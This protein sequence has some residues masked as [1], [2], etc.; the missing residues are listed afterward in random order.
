MLR[1]TRRCGRGGLIVAATCL[2]SGV[3]ASS[4]QADVGIRFTEF[5]L[6][7]PGADNGFEAI[8]INGPANQSLAGVSMVILEGDAGGAGVVDVVIDLS[9]F[10]IGANGLLLLR[11]AATQLQ[12]PPAAGTTVVVQDFFPDLENGSATYL[13]VQGTPPAQFFDIDTN[14]DGVVD[15]WPSGIVIFDAVGWADASNDFTYAA[16][17]GGQA[18]LVSA[19]PNAVFRFYACNA[20][21]AT[22]WA[23]GVIDGANPGPY[24]FSTANGATFGFGEGVVP[25][26][27]LGQGLQFGVSNRE[28]DR[29]ADGT[30]DA[31]DNCLATANPDQADV[32][33]DGV[34]DACDNCVATANADQ[35][36]GDADG[37]GD[38]C[39]NCVATANADQL[40]TDGD[41]LGDAC[42]NCPAVANL[43][44]LDG[45]GDGV[46]DVCDN[47]PLAANPD[48]A[49]T[50]S[51]G[52]ADA[53]DDCPLAF[54]P[55]Q[56][57]LDGD[58]TGEACDTCPGL[59]NP[60]QEDGDGDGLG[61]A[62]DPFGCFADFDGDGLINTVDLSFLLGGWGTPLYDLDGDEEVGSSDIALILGAWGSCP[63]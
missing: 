5:L 41:G 18:Y 59:A 50:D 40:D 8:E 25:T 45:D 60:G 31:C 42:D 61:D 11:D 13:L 57:D 30:V 48:Q 51:D 26:L 32:D 63:G 33:T 38:V 4:V 21:N 47:C 23:G 10:T 9:A 7:P 17:F 49:D 43:D 20:E 15:A 35:A 52:F 6:N 28:V 55:E 3:A 44:Q 24:T 12:P 37:V 54:D 14:N 19:A 27:F 36:D 39:D 34:G 22:D 29:D 2:V 56:A 1:V 58:G 46:G 16:A 62:C 53:C